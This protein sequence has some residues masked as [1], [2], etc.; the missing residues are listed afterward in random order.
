MASSSALDVTSKSAAGATGTAANSG[1]TA[2]T[3]VA[4]EMALGAAVPAATF[5]GYDGSYTNVTMSNSCVAGHMAVAHAG[6][7]V[8]YTATCN[9]DNVYGAIVFTLKPASATRR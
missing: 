6:T 9:E 7:A 5:T 8:S 3:S 2:G 1:T 4:G